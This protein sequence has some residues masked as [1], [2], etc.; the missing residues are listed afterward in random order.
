MERITDDDFMA[1][2]GQILEDVAMLFGEGNNEQR[3]EMIECLK[4]S[5]KLKEDCVV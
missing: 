2:V 4:E 3:K 5:L 1:R